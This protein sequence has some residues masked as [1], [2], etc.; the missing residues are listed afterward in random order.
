MKLRYGMQNY[1]TLMNLASIA[2]GQQQGTKEAEDAWNN[3]YIALA[4]AE[5]AEQNLDESADKS[6]N[7]VDAL[8]VSAQSAA[9]YL[10]AMANT[11]A[12][13]GTHA[14]GMWDVPYDGYRAV[15]H[16]DEMILNASRANDYRNGEGGGSSAVVAAI[17][18]LRNDM[19][20]L[21]LVVGQKTFG[22]AVVDYGGSRMDGYIGQADSTLA[23]GYG[24]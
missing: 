13:G 15:L 20:N 23:A 3:F 6:A 5:Q 22:R 21:K 14:A 4:R 7:S 1:E 9:D 11:Q 12:A 2:N 10:S 8:G 24:S 19:Q 17:Q 18:A 16:R